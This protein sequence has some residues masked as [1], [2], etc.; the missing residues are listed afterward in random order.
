MRQYIALV[1]VIGLMLSA[2]FNAGAQQ[3]DKDKLKKKAE[4]KQGET[5]RDLKDKAQ[6]EKDDRDDDDDDDSN[7]GAIIGGIAAAALIGTVIVKA[8]GGDDKKSSET[9]VSF[10]LMDGNKDGKLSRDEFGS[11]MSKAFASS[12]KDGDGSVTRAEAVAAYGDR[13]GK[14]FDALDSAK[15]GSITMD[16]LDADAS[17]AFR[18]ADA[19]GDGSITA[20]EKTAATADNAKA[21]AEQKK[22]P[23]NVKRLLR[24]VT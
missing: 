12:D 1:T 5:D 9:T 21:E 18:W 7:V 14:Y 17:Q 3:V 22:N 6:D 20:T 2:A 11:A 23:L 13:G 16:A 8:T 24:K 4:E 15:S 10:G 19:D